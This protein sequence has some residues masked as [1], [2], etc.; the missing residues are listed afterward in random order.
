M[1]KRKFVSSNMVESGAELVIEQ[2]TEFSHKTEFSHRTECRV[3]SLN[4]RVR[5]YYGVHVTESM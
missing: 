3:E 4:I 2:R 1:K 5:K